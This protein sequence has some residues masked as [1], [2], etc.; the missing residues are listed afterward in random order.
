MLEGELWVAEGS[1]HWTPSPMSDITNKTKAAQA[2]ASSGGGLRLA[3]TDVSWVRSLA[4]KKPTIEVKLASLSETVMLSF[5]GP[6]VCTTL[7]W[8]SR[9]A[10]GRP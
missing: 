3:S 10:G 8:K 7:S 4:G 9:R 2:G 6:G 5:Q 1:L